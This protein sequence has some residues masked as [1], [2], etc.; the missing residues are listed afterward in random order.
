[1][2]RIRNDL[3]PSP[4]P[5][6]LVI[7]SCFP[8]F[9]LGAYFVILYLGREIFVVRACVCFW[10]D[11]LAYLNITMAFHVLTKKRGSL[12]NNLNIKRKAYEES[13]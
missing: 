12:K 1:M 2:L 8:Q 4:Y 11:G 6:I 3:S 7:F 13:S 5:G 10:V 9:E